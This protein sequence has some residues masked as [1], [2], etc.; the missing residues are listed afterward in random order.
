MAKK[1]AIVV[2]HTHWDREWYLTFQEYRLRL[3]RVLD[4]VLDLLRGNPDFKCFVLD[5]QTCALEDYLELRPE[6][7]SLVRELIASGRLVVGPLYT[8]PDEALASPEALVRNLLTGI[9]IAESYGRAPKIG[10]FPDAFG[11]IPQ[12][13]QILREFDIEAFFFTRGLG[14]EEEELGT[15]FLWEAPDGSR[16][17]AVYLAEGYC[18]ANMLGVEK[19]LE[20]SVW[21]SP[22]GWYTAFLEAYF[23]EPEPDLEKARERVEELAE[24]LLPKTP[25]GTLLLMNG[26]DHRPPQARIVEIVKLLNSLDLGIELEQGSLEDYVERAR[27]RIGKLRVH[28]GELRGSKRHPILAGT[29]SSRAY[30]KRLNYR[31]QVLLEKY[32]EPL[33][34]IAM[35]EGEEYPKRPLSIAWKLVLQNQAHDSI[36]GTSI[37][38]VHLENESRYLQSIALASNIAYERAR[39]VAEK[40]CR[41]GQ[42][43]IFVYNPSNW[44]RTDLVLVAFPAEVDVDA[45]VA[46]DDEGNELPL[47]SLAIEEGPW[48]NAKLAAFVAKDVPPL[49]YRTYRLEERPCRRATQSPGNAIENEYFRV[50]ADPERGGALR[51]LDKESGAVY[52]GFNVFVDEGDAGDEYNYSPPKERDLVVESTSFRASVERVEGPAVSALRIKLEMEVPE[53]LEGQSRSESRVAIPLT[54]EVYLYR[55]VRRIDIRTTVLNKAMD[56]RLRVKFPTGLMAD[57][58]AADGHFYVVEREVGPAG[59]RDW[60]EIPTTY[61]QLYWVDVSDGERGVT[62]ANRGIPEYEARLEG[63]VTVYLTLF[64]SVGWLSR[65]DL[66]TRR[67]HAGPAVRTPGAQCLRE[68]LF[69]YSVIPHTG[70]WL[71]SRSYKLAREF[72]E[73]LMGILLRNLR[74]A[75]REVVRVEPEEDYGPAIKALVDRAAK[76]KSV[77][78]V[79]P[80]NS[81]LLR[82]AYENSENV[83]KVALTVTGTLTPHPGV[84]PA[85]NT[86]LIA[87]TVVNMVKRLGE[88]LVVFDGISDL[89][90]VNDVRSVYVMLRHVIELLPRTPLLAIV[91]WKALSEREY[92]ALAALF[93]KV[94]VLRGGGLA[95]V[96]S[97]QLLS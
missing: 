59:S 34:C 49:G 96:R 70:T 61:P 15:E 92:S 9:R 75:S 86:P 68:M 50:E 20:L 28:R 38:P 42:P 97:S 13:P 88:A 56:H 65:G 4:K 39:Y 45:L 47:Q 5:G 40:C 81:P 23:E 60:I 90:L 64:R 77:V 72:A 2:S 69:E 66:Q 7:E 74:P 78:I 27:R 44:P 51:I 26:C 17:L 22:D 18:N 30:L 85:S 87:S 76:R 73:P 29:L 19:S 46:I 14:D 3:V 89:V 71:S 6:N 41:G 53:K 58:V 31:A 67:G 43:S 52:E 24:R 93:D 21:R 25:S 35:L 48:E 63:G 8:Q 82:Q 57:R 37:D 79:A 55:G 94:C 12:L 16:V 91:N 11:H 1:E 62:I 95:A 33:S 83:F 80:L 36:C 32:A 10:Y 54:S 84:V